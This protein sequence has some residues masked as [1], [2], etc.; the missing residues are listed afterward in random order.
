MTN[1]NTNEF[2]VKV[3]P[4]TEEQRRQSGEL[5]ADLSRHHPPVEAVPGVGGIPGVQP[6]N[7]G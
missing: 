2:V 6:T 4:V 3:T 1:T 5:A 7:Q